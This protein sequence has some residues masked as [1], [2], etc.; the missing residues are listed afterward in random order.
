MLMYRTKGRSLAAF[1]ALLVVLLLT[2]DT[3]FQQV[4]HLTDA[5]ILQDT[6][7]TIPRVIQ[8]DPD[9]LR[10]RKFGLEQGAVDREL[11]AVGKYF[12]Y[13][14]GTQPVPFGNGARS[15]IPVSC[16]SNNCTWAAYDTLAVCS[17]CADISQTFNLTQTCLNTTLDWSTAWQGPLKTVPYPKG[18]VCG[19]FANI[20]SEA[21]ILFSGYS[22]ALSDN[23]TAGETLLVRT[24]P[25]VDFNTK[26]PFYG[27]GSISFKDVRYPLVDFLVASAKDGIQSVKRGEPPVIHECMLTWCIQTLQSS[28]DNGEYIETVKSKYIERPMKTDPWPW[29]TYEVQGG[30]WIEYTQNITIT[31]PIPRVDLAPYNS[32]NVT[33]ETYRVDRSVHQLALNYFDDFLPSYFAA[34]SHVGAP[35]LRF[36]NYKA[37]PET[38]DSLEFNPWL[39]PNN[40]TRHMERFATAMTNSVRSSRT[41]EMLQ[42]K[43]YEVETHISIAWAWLNFPFIILFLSVIFLISTIIKTSDDGSKLWKTSTMPALIYSLPRDVQKDISNPDASGN[44]VS[45]KQRKVKIKLLPDSGWRVSGHIRRST[46]RTPPGWI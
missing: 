19:Y 33:N 32:S 18:T 31:P 11:S 45:E 27:S 4:V 35:V 42:G 21:P 9:V 23:A 41:K 2:I 8:Y 14:N 28:Y 7:G 44:S 16:P 36:A 25:L 30:Q 6:S 5:W 3:F 43:S 12:F 1:G 26:A 17:K 13:G 37:G 34:Q 24:V 38:L 15:E 39:S 29:L 20:T 46:P 10:A 40:V 22:V